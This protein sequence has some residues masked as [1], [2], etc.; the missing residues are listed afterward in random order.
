MQGTDNSGNHLP[1]RPGHPRC[2]V[3]AEDAR[4]P[5][6][7]ARLPAQ[8]LP[9]QLGE[10]GAGS[11]AGSPP[12]L[13]PSADPGGKF[14][15]CGKCGRR[16]ASARSH[17][18]SS[19]FIVYKI[20]NPSSLLPRHSRI[21]RSA[22]RAPPNAARGPAAPGP[23]AAPGAYSLCLGDGNEQ[24]YCLK[25]LKGLA[26]RWGRPDPLFRLGPHPNPSPGARCS[27]KKHACGAA[28]RAQAHRG[29]KIL[30]GWKGKK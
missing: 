14:A 25:R 22:S 3:P 16:E 30:T 7:D 24:K 26:F 5:A 28:G 10:G 23:L 1:P 12:R 20:L 19:I 6:E 4:R 15:G 11:G 8:E 27:V 9:G 2:P 17:R 21:K 18:R 13:L 29:G